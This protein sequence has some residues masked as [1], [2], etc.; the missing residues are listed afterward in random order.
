MSGSSA[1]SNPVVESRWSNVDGQSGTSNRREGMMRR[2]LLVLIGAL[3][4]VASHALVAA[5]ARNLATQAAPRKAAGNGASR[6]A[7][8]WK[9]VS[10]D[11]I[12]PK[13]EVLP[14]ANPQARPQLGFIMYDPA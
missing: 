10:V 2:N 7:G 4:I 12:G 8:N 9:L 11:R 3:G 1:K 6:F 14:P 5:P 13:G